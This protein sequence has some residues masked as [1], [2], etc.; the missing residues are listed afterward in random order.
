[1]GGHKQL[2]RERIFSG[3]QFKGTQFKGILCHSSEV[4]AVWEK[5]IQ[6]GWEASWSH[7]TIFRKLRV[8]R[9]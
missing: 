4:K 8:N 9:K 5:S 3:S 1:M 2:N 7:H 6:L